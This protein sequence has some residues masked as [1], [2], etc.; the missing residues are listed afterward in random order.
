M[1][2][3]VRGILPS[4]PSQHKLEMYKEKKTDRFDIGLIKSF[5]WKLMRVVICYLGPIMRAFCKLG[6][7]KIRKSS[8]M[9]THLHRPSALK[10]LKEDFN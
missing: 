1:V 8:S 7:S 4:D 2:E 10:T 9:H 5:V 6:I 3:H